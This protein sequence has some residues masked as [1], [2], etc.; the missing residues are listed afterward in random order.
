MSAFKNQEFS[1]TS[2]LLASLAESEGPAFWASP[3][4]RVRRL[5]LSSSHSCGPSAPLRLAT[6]PGHPTEGIHPP[7]TPKA[8]GVLMP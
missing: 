6:V 5:E 4:P 8:F 3:L 2:D 7:G 1:H